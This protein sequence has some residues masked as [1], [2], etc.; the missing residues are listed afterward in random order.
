VF[1]YIFLTNRRIL[2]WAA[3][4][5]FLAPCFARAAEPSILAIRGG[6]VFDSIAGKMQPDRTIIIEGSL[7]K[8]VGT[9]EKPAAIPENA[10]VIDARGKFII[11]GLIEGNVHRLLPPH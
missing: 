10:R 3:V 11:P 1:R 5:L 8:A 4:A 2:S 9:P 6:S 7:I